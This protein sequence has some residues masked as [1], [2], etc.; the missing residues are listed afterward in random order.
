MDR[1][2]FDMSNTQMCRGSDGAC[3]QEVKWR[4]FSVSFWWKKGGR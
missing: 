1:M 3:A 4:F 2:Y